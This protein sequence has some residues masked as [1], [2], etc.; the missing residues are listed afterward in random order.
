MGR[1]EE[2]EEGKRGKKKRGQSYWS[3]GRGNE[4]GGGYIAMKIRKREKAK[5]N[6]DEQQQQA[7][8][9]A[10]LLRTSPPDQRALDEES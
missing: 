9:M 6:D 7:S 2:D 8:V 1:W 4:M 10:V 3:K 5:A